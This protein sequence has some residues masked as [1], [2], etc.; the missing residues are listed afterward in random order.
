MSDNKNNDCQD[1]HSEQGAKTN[2]QG[3][4]LEDIQKIVNRTCMDNGAIQK[5]ENIIK[6]RYGRTIRKSD[7]LTYQ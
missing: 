2:P 6:T 1:I 3:N 7:R 5:G 4:S